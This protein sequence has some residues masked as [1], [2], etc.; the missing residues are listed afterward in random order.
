ML[1]CTVRPSGYHQKLLILK[2]KTKTTL[3]VGVAQV[4]P[5]RLDRNATT[6]RVIDWIRDAASRGCELVVFREALVPGY[7]LWV[8]RTDGGLNCWSTGAARRQPS[9]WTSL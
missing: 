1:I 5:I 9:S 2:N 6:A 3:K 7:P 4:A 8:E